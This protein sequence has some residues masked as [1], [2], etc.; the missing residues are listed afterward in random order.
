MPSLPLLMQAGKDSKVF[1]VLIVTAMMIPSQSP[2]KGPRV[3]GPQKIW[4][5][6]L[7]LRS[8]LGGM[9]A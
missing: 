4:N 8:V 2:H 6:N 9:V 1:S 7:S 3:L 5:G